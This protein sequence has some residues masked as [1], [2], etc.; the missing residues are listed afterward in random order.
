MK[1]STKATLIGAFIIT[2]GISIGYFGVQKFEAKR[3]IWL[4][5]GLFVTGVACQLIESKIPKKKKVRKNVNVT[6]L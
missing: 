3:L 6:S 4:G 2:V 1:R 5:G